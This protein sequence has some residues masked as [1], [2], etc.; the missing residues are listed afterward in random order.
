M[1][2]G[3][4]YAEAF[5]KKITMEQAIGNSIIKLCIQKIKELTEIRNLNKEEFI[6]EFI[7]YCNLPAEDEY[8]I[9]FPNKAKDI[10][11]AIKGKMPENVYYTKH[12]DD[13]FV[14]RQNTGE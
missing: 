8:I 11:S 4:E 14:L 12:I 5:C 10:F 13:I 1:L 2:N 6:K 3:D 9:L 7:E